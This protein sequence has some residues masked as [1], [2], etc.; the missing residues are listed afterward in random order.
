MINFSEVKY[1]DFKELVSFLKSSEDENEFYVIVKRL[2]RFIENM[3]GT[4]SV[5]LGNIVKDILEGKEKEGEE[6]FNVFRETYPTLQVDPEG[7][8]EP[9]KIK[10]FEVALQGCEL[11]YNR[12]KEALNNSNNI[13]KSPN[14]LNSQVIAAKELFPLINMEGEFEYPMRRALYF[15]KDI[16]RPLSIEQF[17]LA[18][19][20]LKAIFGDK[21][22]NIMGKFLNYIFNKKTEN[23][24]WFVNHFL[25]RLDVLY[26]DEEMIYPADKEFY[27]NLKKI[28]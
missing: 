27:E 8:L 12:A 7:K 14:H 9:E 28:G 16:N 17:K 18:D 3:T 25:T 2:T 23:C 22:H 24:Y 20:Q 26:K 1:E 21:K 4:Q 11:V 19:L 10:Y 5:F 15:K 13:D 6:L